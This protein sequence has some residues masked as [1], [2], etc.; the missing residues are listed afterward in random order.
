MIT[1]ISI[2]NDIFAY[3]LNATNGE[4][5][6][7]KTFTSNIK[8]IIIIKLFFLITNKNYLVAFSSVDGKIIYSYN[9]NQKVLNF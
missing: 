8:P 2:F 7:K 4:I 9:I 5:L 1:I 3:I 6:F